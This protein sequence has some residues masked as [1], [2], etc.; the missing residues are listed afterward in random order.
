[1]GSLDSLLKNPSS[2]IAGSNFCDEAIS[3]NFKRPEVQGQKTVVNQ[4]NIFFSISL[5]FTK[6]SIHILS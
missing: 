2:V 1:M 3:N 6:S 4:R 5:A